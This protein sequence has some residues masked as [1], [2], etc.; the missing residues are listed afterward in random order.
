MGSLLLRLRNK[1][2]LFNFKKQKR[3]GIYAGPRLMTSPTFLDAG[4]SF[5][6]SGVFSLF[7]RPSGPNMLLSNEEDFYMALEKLK[8]RLYG[9]LFT[10]CA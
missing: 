2:L 4:F 3:T 8:N 9:I 1:L 10:V 7:L 5:T 6:F